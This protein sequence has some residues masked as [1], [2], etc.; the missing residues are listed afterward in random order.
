[1]KIKQL[2]YL[3]VHLVKI[4]KMS[5]WKQFWCSHIYKEISDEYLRKER[6]SDGVGGCGYTTFEVHAKRNK[7]LKCGKIK[8]TEKRLIC[9]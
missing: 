9:L 7:C 6:I 3:S 8:I 2:L 5:K 1:M 4:N